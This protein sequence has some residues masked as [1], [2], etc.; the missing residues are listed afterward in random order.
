MDGGKLPKQVPL[1]RGAFERLVEN[2]AGFFKSNAK[3]AYNI[4]SQNG[5]YVGN[6]LAP[7]AA[8]MPLKKLIDIQMSLAKAFEDLI[9]RPGSDQ[10]IMRELFTRV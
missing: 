9:Q 5:W 10:M 7:I 4:F 1:P 6:K 8:K 2:E 3:S